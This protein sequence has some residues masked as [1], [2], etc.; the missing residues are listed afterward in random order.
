MNITTE[1]LARSLLH[2][3]RRLPHR[4]PDHHDPDPVR[5][6]RTGPRTGRTGTPRATPFRRRRQHPLTGASA[7]HHQALA[8]T[9][10][11]L[12]SAGRNTLRRRRMTKQRRLT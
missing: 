7:P 4:A 1:E 10:V 12:Q 3:R 5:H 11:R 8:A 6:L 9:Q 2:R